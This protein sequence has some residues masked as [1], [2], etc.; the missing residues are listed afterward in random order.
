MIV[1]KKIDMKYNAAVDNES[2]SDSCGDYE[3]QG[4]L[5]NIESIGDYESQEEL[6]N[7]E[8][9]S[10]DLCGGSSKIIETDMIE[11]NVT[12]NSE[13]KK[14]VGFEEKKASIYADIQPQHSNYTSKKKGF[15]NINGQKMTSSQGNMHGFHSKEF[16]H[17]KNNKSNVNKSSVENHSTNKSTGIKTK[18][19]NK[20]AFGPRRSKVDISRE[21]DWQ[22]NSQP[23]MNSKQ[24]FDFRM[25]KINSNSFKKGNSNS[26]K[27]LQSN[28]TLKPTQ[29]L[30]VD[31]K[32]FEVLVLGTGSGGLAFTHRAT[33]YGK[34]VAVIEN[35][36]IGGVCQTT[37]GVPQKIM[38]NLGTAMR[39][40]KNLTTKKALELPGGIEYNWSY[41]K[42]LRNEYSAASR[43]E[44]V[45]QLVGEGTEII[46]GYGRFVDDKSI[47][48]GNTIYTAKHIMISTGSRPKKLVGFPGVEFTKPP[49]EFYELEK[50][51]KSIFIV[52]SGYIAMELA[53]ICFN[54]GIKVNMSVRDDRVLKHFDKELTIKLTEHMCEDGIDIIKHNSPVKFE[55]VDP[56]DVKNSQIIVYMRDDTVILVD[57]VF[58]AIG[59]EPNTDNIGQENTSIKLGKTKGIEVDSFGSTT[60][61]DVYAI[62]DCINKV[63]LTPVAI[64]EGRILA[65]RLYNNKHSLKMDYNFIPS[66]VFSH[67]PIASVGLTEDEA[68]EKYG[69]DEIRVYTSEFKHMFYA[70][71]EPN[72]NEKCFMKLIT[73]LNGD[74]CSMMFSRQ[75]ARKK[76]IMDDVR[77]S[78]FAPYDTSAGFSG[79]RLS[80]R[81]PEQKVVNLKKFTTRDTISR[82][83]EFRKIDQVIFF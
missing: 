56:S 74:H 33:E 52:G 69:Q 43:Q 10:T 44:S 73:I 49:W 82:V 6:S 42:T 14:V 12:K 34:Q 59:R 17:V 57:H 31:R 68:I 16:K 65:E 64:R 53:G 77:K 51:P 3:S 71:A 67:I 20:P 41:L 50:K 79:L 8:S 32:H 75:L 38:Y 45:E 47:Q 48:V 21:Q 83:D 11:K 58:C 76:T 39:E 26:T 46:K 23:D 25:S 2:L 19:Q 63:G 37:G 54:F 60:A 62:G 66:V 30:E 55:L 18:N 81:N 13:T 80:M 36:D 27:K 78:T 29:K 9:T 70:L 1:A 4:E 72:N 28:S 61:S 24:S 40:I 5:S 15:G 7:I 35:K 22:W